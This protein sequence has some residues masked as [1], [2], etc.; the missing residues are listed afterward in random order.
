MARLAGSLLLDTGICTVEGWPVVE[1]VVAKLW[2]APRFTAP[3]ICHEKL[4]QPY[5]LAPE[6]NSLHQINTVSGHSGSIYPLWKD[7]TCLRT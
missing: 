4:L 6:I 1:R 7:A 3:G 5:G 2:D